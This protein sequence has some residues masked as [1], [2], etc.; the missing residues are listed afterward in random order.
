M[1]C[2]LCGEQMRLVQLTP[3]E[4]MF[5]AGYEHLTLE[6]VGCGETDR[7]LVFRYR[8]NE[9]PEIQRPGHETSCGEATN[10][11]VAK[12]AEEPANHRQAS[13]PKSWDR[14]IEKLRAR[15]NELRQRAE[16]DRRTD[17]D[18]ELNPPPNYRVVP[19]AAARAA[20]ELRRRRM[21]SMDNPQEMESRENFAKFWDGLAHDNVSPP[22]AA[23]FTCRMAP[24]PRSMSLIV[25]PLGALVSIETGIGASRPQPGGQPR[26]PCPATRATQKAPS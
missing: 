9:F 26:P 6:C 19:G 17:W 1:R 14:A 24:L 10:V 13:G 4:T 21:T 20:A 12:A 15:Q 16:K 2:I 8:G 11:P 22:A 7:R 18:A 25:K 3:D 5:V 23:A